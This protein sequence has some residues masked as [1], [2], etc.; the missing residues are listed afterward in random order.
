MGNYG[1]SMEAS[2]VNKIKPLGMKFGGWM[3]NYVSSFN[4]LA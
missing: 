4:P 1:L 3:G 2:L